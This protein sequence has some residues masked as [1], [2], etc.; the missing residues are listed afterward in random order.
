VIA[1]PFGL[2]SREE[3]RQMAAQCV[4]DIVNLV[5]EQGAR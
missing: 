4:R 2:R 3:V 5:G 1:H